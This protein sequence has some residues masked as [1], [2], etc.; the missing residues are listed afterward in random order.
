MG[1]P[2]LEIIGMIVGLVASRAY[3]ENRVFGVDQGGGQKSIEHLAPLVSVIVLR[4]GTRP[5]DGIL[6]ATAHSARTCS[7]DIARTRPS[8]KFS[9]QSGMTINKR[10]ELLLSQ[11]ADNTDLAQRFNSAIRSV[12]YRAL[13]KRAA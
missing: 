10:I 4:Q 5:R 11:Q 6:G 2:C 12:G 1:I 7:A 8:V 13:Q 3:I 9:W